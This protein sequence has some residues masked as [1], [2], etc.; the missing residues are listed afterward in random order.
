[1]GINME[2]EYKLDKEYNVWEIL[3]YNLRMWWLAAIFALAGAVILGGYKYKSNHHLVEK[4][5]YNNVQQATASVYVKLYSDETAIERVN[6]MIKI[7]DSGRAYDHLIANTGWEL[8]YKGYL[9]LFDM[10]QG[11]VS[12]IAS[13]YVNYPASYENFDISD[14]AMAVRYTEEI[15]RAVDEVSQEMIGQECIEILDEPYATQIVQKIDSYYITASEFKQSVLKAA[16]SGVLL[17]IIVEVILYTCWMLLYKKPKNAEEVRQCLMAPVIDTL[18][19]GATKEETYRKVTL[20]LK[21]EETETDTAAGCR[22]VNC[23]S[24]HSPNEET[25]LKVAMSYAKEQKKT[26]FINLA[27]GK[28]NEGGDNSISAYILEGKNQPKPRSLHPYLD[29][30]CRNVGAEGEFDLVAN[31]RFAEYL[32]EKDREYECIVINSSDISEGIDAFAAAKLC[33]KTFFVCSRKKVTNEMLYRVKNEAD[34]YGI[35]INGILIYE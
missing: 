12:D 22:R 19:S 6:T 8:D 23:M 35:K 34:V 32:D 21:D 5:V 7:A 26:L 14:E 4:E 15:V 16:T 1:M 9:E 33:D 11:E 20:S 13:V 18:K 30:V 17:G 24:L 10:I 2:K 28:E 27:A 29:A 25:A 3:K 31:R